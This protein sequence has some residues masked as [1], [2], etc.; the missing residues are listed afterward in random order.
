M[1]E[2]KQKQEEEKQEQEEEKQ[3][4]KEENG[5]NFDWSIPEESSEES[6]LEM[7]KRKFS[8]LRKKY[9]EVLEENKRLKASN[10]NTA[11]TRTADAETVGK[12]DSAIYNMF[13]RKKE[14]K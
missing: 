9:V 3:E 11:L 12:A 7:G 2:E 8:E 4:Q 5:G 1:N 13:I 10:L 14:E 6:E